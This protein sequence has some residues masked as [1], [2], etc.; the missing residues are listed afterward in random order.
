MKEARKLQ[1]VDA[2]E[3]AHRVKKGERQRVR[4]DVEMKRKDEEAMR[5][6]K[7]LSQLIADLMEAVERHRAVAET[8]A[9]E[10]TR[11]KAALKQNELNEKEKQDVAIKF[12][13]LKLMAVERLKFVE[14]Q[15][16]QRDSSQK[17]YPSRNGDNNVLVRGSVMSVDDTLQQRIRKCEAIITEKDGEI[18]VLDQRVLVLLDMVKELEMKRLDVSVAVPHQKQMFLDEREERQEPLVVID[19][20]HRRATNLASEGIIDDDEPSIP[21]ERVPSKQLF[22]PMALEKDFILRFDGDMRETE[23]FLKSEDVT[24]KMF[25]AEAI[26]WSLGEQFK[27]IKVM[28][29]DVRSGSVLV[30]FTL[31]SDAVF[32][33]GLL[34]D[35]ER[36]MKQKI[37]GIFHEPWTKNDALNWKLRSLEAVDENAGNNAE[38]Q[39][40]PPPYD[41]WMKCLAET[42]EELKLAKDEMLSQGEELEKVQSMLNQKEQELEALKQRVKESESNKAAKEKESSFA[43]WASGVEEEVEGLEAQILQNRID[44]A[45]SELLELIGAQKDHE[46]IIAKQQLEIGRL[47]AALNDTKAEMLDDDEGKK[48]VSSFTAWIS[49]VDEDK[50]AQLLQNKID[51]A[52]NELVELLGA[53]KNHEVIIGKQQLEI[54]RLKAALKDTES[55]L[56]SMKNAQ[57][58]RGQDSVLV[59]GTMAHTLDRQSA[60]LQRKSIEKEMQAPYDKWEKCLLKTTEQ[61][62]SARDEML[63]QNEQLQKVHEVLMQK[64]GKLQDVKASLN[65]KEKELKVMRKQAQ[66][67]QDQVT[68]EKDAQIEELKVKM[69]RK[70][71]ERLETWNG[72]AM[73]LEEERLKSSTMIDAKNR[74]SH[75]QMVDS[76]RKLEELKE[77]HDQEVQQ[78]IVELEKKEKELE[79]LRANASKRDEQFAGYRLSVQE[80]VQETILMEEVESDEDG[81][82]SNDDGRDRR[83]VFFDLMEKEERIYL[84]K[85][86]IGEMESMIKQCNQENE[87]LRDENHNAREEVHRIQRTLTEKIWNLDTV[88]SD[89]L[90]DVREHAA[91]IKMMK[92]E[93]VS[94]EKQIESLSKSVKDQK[95]ELDAKDQDLREVQEQSA[96]I[97]EM[98]SELV[99]RLKQIDVDS[100]SE[101]V[102]ERKA[103]LDANDMQQREIEERHGTEMQAQKLEFL[104]IEKEK[105]EIVQQIDALMETIE[106]KDEELRRLND[107]LKLK[108]ENV[109]DL[110]HRVFV[111]ESEFEDYRH[112]LQAIIGNVE[113][114]GGDERMIAMQKEGQIRTLN[115]QIADAL[116]EIAGLQRVIESKD[117]DI[118]EQD[119]FIRKLDQEIVDLTEAQTAQRIDVKELTHRL[120]EG[121]RQ[122]VNADAELKRKEADIQW[123][124]GD[125]RQVQ[126]RIVELKDAVNHHEAVASKQKS[127]IKRLNAAL[128]K[129]EH[130]RYVH[131]LRL[132]NE[133]NTKNEMNRALHDEVA[134][135][136]EEIDVL[137]NEMD[138][139][140]GEFSRNE[141]KNLEMQKTAA[142]RMEAALKSMDEQKESIDAK[143][144]E[145]QDIQERAARVQKL[146]R[147]LVSRLKKIDIDSLSEL[148]N[149]QKVVIDTKDIELQRLETTV[150]QQEIELEELNQQLSIKNVKNDDIDFPDGFSRISSCSSLV[151]HRDDNKIEN[152]MERRSVDMTWESLKLIAIERLELVEAQEREQKQ[153]KKAG[154][155]LVRTNV[156]EVENTFHLQQIARIERLQQI[157][158]EQQRK[159][160]RSGSVKRWT[161]GFILTLCTVGVL[162]FVA[163]LNNPEYFNDSIFGQQQIE[164]DDEYLFDVDNDD[165]EDLNGDQK[166]MVHLKDQLERTIAEQTKA[167]EQADKLD[168]VVLENESELQP[169]GFIFEGLKEDIEIK[170]RLERATAEQS[171]ADKA[172]K[173][174]FLEGSAAENEALRSRIGE[175]EVEN[176]EESDDGQIT[177]TASD[178]V[179]ALQERVMESED[180]AEVVENVL[181]NDIEDVQEPVGEEQVDDSW[182]SAFGVIGFG[183]VSALLSFLAIGKYFAWNPSPHGTKLWFRSREHGYMS[184]TFVNECQLK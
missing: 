86:Q 158:I 60:R 155:V 129:N 79:A 148:V 160:Q 180:A 67:E 144:L 143:E 62:A 47:N 165:E 88:Q 46:V 38:P 90:R 163:A 101:M 107:A 114:V 172:D 71:V 59:R 52:S 24:V 69:R 112:T 53:Q 171:E 78:M 76:N 134:K 73:L 12:A 31:R 121:E 125:L 18:D 108:E 111:R 105:Q 50:E 95:A 135:A 116:R 57:E 8:Q 109:E 56:Q 145:L 41:K 154:N 153:M 91:E 33:G 80:M 110:T 182:T 94:R 92:A 104:E 19:E 55:E 175:S 115:I 103:N 149:E 127:E 27:E 126:Q 122:R 170:N 146:N 120:K 89:K 150:H 137:R 22:K 99:S 181:E 152:L 162:T 157:I 106:D 183:M 123:I 2:K 142:K 49:E 87:A 178:D 13:S 140:Q 28:V 21:A 75:E 30:A 133:W 100:L 83:S 70:S 132:S 1:Q 72:M 167:E 25:A 9:S 5:R 81:T 20:K 176:A 48:R 128:N 32:D 44:E 14:A 161:L 36:K 6:E 51:D 151:D 45:S 84:L 26:R 74:M 64:H 58:R 118:A 4:A 131:V 130:E 23:E 136:N 169:D 113:S 10:S 3:L 42:T 184:S 63:T 97:Q 117:K 168:D 82:V 124:T 11:L 54:D 35:A 40:T 174:L 166:Q 102:N 119:N 96:M 37:G 177:G 139:M 17:S 98:N 29:N 93:I 141:A 159:N 34:Q 179:S 147:D 7:E 173:I 15:N 61:L 138:R 39:Q 156:V 85:V 66:M 164:I 68:K 43:V 77:E 65:E 16:K